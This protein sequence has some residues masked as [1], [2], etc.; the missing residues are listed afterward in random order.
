MVEKMNKALSTDMNSTD[1]IPYFLWD[2]PMTIAEV[3]N[4][5]ASMA[6]PKKLI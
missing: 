2:E 5:L 3:K 1:A 6:F 4:R